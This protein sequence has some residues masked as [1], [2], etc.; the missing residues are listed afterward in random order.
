MKK[1]FSLILFLPLLTAQAHTLGREFAS[2]EVK[3]EETPNIT[4]G[5]TIRI[6]ILAKNEKGKEFKTPGFLAPGLLKTAEWVNFKVEVSGGTLNNDGSITIS[7][8]VRDLKNNAVTITAFC[9]KNPEVK[10]ELAIPL[11]FQGKLTLMMEG[12]PGK[13]GQSGTDGKVGGTSSATNS[14][15]KPGNG[16]TGGSGSDGGDGPD[17]DVFI[18]LKQSASLKKEMVYVRMVNKTTNEEKIAMVDP[19]NSELV[20]MVN[21]G[22]GGAGGYGGSGGTG[23]MNDQRKVSSDGGNGGEGGQ[24][25]NGGRGGSLTIYLDP[26]TDKVNMT[27]NFSNQGGRGGRGGEGGNGGTK[28]A[29]ESSYGSK[30]TQ[31]TRGNDGEKGPDVKTIKQKVEINE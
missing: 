23:G 9:V 8:N 7:D 18:T 25:G 6:G 20:V 5:Q 26:S 27:L 13:R 19:N 29:Y 3:Y 28:G 31:G 14:A 2:I 1:L 11:N 30:G 4:L 16:G 22:E 24:G 21:G 17:V 10:T 15:P 12:K